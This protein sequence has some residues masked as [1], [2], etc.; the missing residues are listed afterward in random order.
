MATAVSLRVPSVRGLAQLQWASA[1]ILDAVAQ[2]E[3]IWLAPNTPYLC[4]S[5]PTLAD[6]AAIGD[7]ESVEFLQPDYSNNPRFIAWR[8][9]LRSRASFKAAHEDFWPII[10]LMSG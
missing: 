9:R 5:S 2:I 6:V 3:H 4:G 7:L 10:R 1:A 8:D